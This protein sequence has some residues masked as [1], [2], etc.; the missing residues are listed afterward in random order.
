MAV[1]EER[2]SILEN[3]KTTRRWKDIALELSEE[4]NCVK[5]V[6]LATE[7]CEAL[8]HEEERQRQ[9]SATSPAAH[10]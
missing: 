10:P 3:K 7:L 1:Q 8:N 6:E 4:Q 5:R 2:D 9:P